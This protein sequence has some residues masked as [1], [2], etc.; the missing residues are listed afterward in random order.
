LNIYIADQYTCISY[1]VLVVEIS[2]F[3]FSI[4]ESSHVLLRL[5]EY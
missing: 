3:Q 5:W 1:D 2:M 4:T